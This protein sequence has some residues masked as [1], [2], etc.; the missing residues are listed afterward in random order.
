[1]YLFITLII[2]VLFFIVGMFLTTNL[3]YD[4]QQNTHHWSFALEIGQ[5]AGMFWGFGLGLIIA[6]VLALVF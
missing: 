6:S 1:M 2:G 4:L 5:R 3:H